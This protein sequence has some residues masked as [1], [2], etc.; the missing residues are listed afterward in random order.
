MNGQTTNLI[1]TSKF[2]VLKSDQF[3]LVFTKDVEFMKNEKILGLKSFDNIY[4]IE[5]DDEEFRKMA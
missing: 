2:L 5:M 4:E 1:F 3:L